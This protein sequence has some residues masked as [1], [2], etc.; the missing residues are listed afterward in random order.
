ML[1]PEQREAAIER[2]TRAM[3]DIDHPGLVGLDLY[4]ADAL[5]ALL[6]GFVVIPK[7]APAVVRPLAERWP[8]GTVH[9]YRCQGD[10]VRCWGAGACY[11]ATGQ[12]CIPC[13]GSCVERT[14]AVLPWESIN[15]EGAKP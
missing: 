14:G 3:R 9:D 7:D 8:D 1:T 12:R 6:S 15:N 10:C 11:V 5:D 2:M 4:A 13:T